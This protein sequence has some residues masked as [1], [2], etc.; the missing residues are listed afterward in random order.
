MPAG[1]LRNEADHAMREALGLLA[2]EK[3]RTASLIEC[4]MRRYGI[5]AQ[6]LTAERLSAM[7]N[8]ALF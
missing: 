8:G 3:A 7:A 2:Y 6:R 5:K 1:S 4:M